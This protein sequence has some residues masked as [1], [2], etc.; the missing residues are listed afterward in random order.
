MDAAA[1]L[2]EADRSHETARERAHRAWINADRIRRISDGLI[3]FGPWGVGLDGILAWVP[4]ANVAYSVGGG[5]LLVHEALAARAS[6][7]TL[8]RMGLYLTAN[9]AMDGV[10]V[11]GW[12]LDTLFRAHAMAARALQKD[13]E[14]RHGLPPGVAPRR[15]WRWGLRDAPGE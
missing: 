11:I 2:A 1:R 13:I 5:V 10:P 7:A 8:A 9:T 15:R 3:M 12:A 14:A 4:G 6:P